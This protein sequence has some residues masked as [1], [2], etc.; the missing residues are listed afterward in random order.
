[1]KYTPD[2][3]AQALEIVES[4]MTQVSPHAEYEEL[5]QILC[6]PSRW[7]EAHDLFGRIRTNITLPLE[8]HNKTDLDS[9]FVYVA[10]NFLGEGYTTGRDGALYSADGRRRVRFTESDL[11][12]AHG[13]V[14][15][16]GHFEFNGGRN[17]HIPLKP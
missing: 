10:E 13:N 11:T 17:I 6:D 8:A 1:M 9:L 4:L 2:H 14:G 12:G 15:P 3:A 7:H 5:C 16:H